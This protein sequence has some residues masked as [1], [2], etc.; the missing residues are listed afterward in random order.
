MKL[1]RAAKIE[2]SKE[3]AGDLKA[4]SQ[5]FLTEYQGLKF[6][7]LA[8]LRGKLRPM[9]ARYSVIKNSLVRN[10]LSNAGIQG[11]KALFRGPIGMVT[12]K[13]DDPVATAKTLVAFAKDFEKLKIKAAFVGGKWLSAEECKRLSQLA[14]KPEQIAKLAGV[15][16]SAY[17][18]SAWVLSAP[19]S[20]L[21]YAL[22]ALETKKK[23]AAPAAA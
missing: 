10:A 6:V 21:V 4:Q 17:A 19:L 13:T 22:Q 23:E 2:K 5:I 1:T 18:Q 14:S 11:D 9:G 12:C 16:Y 20:K 7:D 15:L 8:I 3:L